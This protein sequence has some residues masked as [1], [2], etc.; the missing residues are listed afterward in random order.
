M[1]SMAT[2]VRNTKNIVFNYFFANSPSAVFCHGQLMHCYYE[3]LLYYYVPSR[4][5]S[6]RGMLLRTITVLLRT[7]NVL[8]RTID[9]ATDYVRKNNLQCRTRKGFQEV[10]ANKHGAIY[11]YTIHLL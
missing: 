4:K 2:L 6:E 1:A 9:V 3:P 8:L 10:H 7:I 11:V 5:F